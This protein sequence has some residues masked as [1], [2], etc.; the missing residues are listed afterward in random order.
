MS[1]DASQFEPSVTL[2]GTA[3]TDPHTFIAMLANELDASL[4]GIG[5]HYHDPE[6]GVEVIK[7]R[8]GRHQLS[9]RLRH[10]S[11]P[12]GEIRLH[13]R[14]P[15]TGADID[16]IES[17]LARALPALEVVL[18]SLQSS[19]SSDM[20][21]DTALQN[22]AAL[23]RLLARARADDDGPTALLIVKIDEATDPAIKRRVALQLA[24]VLGDPDR[25]YRIGERTF[26]VA[27]YR[28]DHTAAKFLAERIRMMVAAMPVALPS[29]TVTVAL[30]KLSASA[31][32]EA[33]LV[34]A[35]A[36][37]EAHSA[38]HNRVIT[39]SPR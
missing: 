25:A 1:I 37:L 32:S 20:D 16:R 23:V 31:R 30:T 26:A 15:F 29:P 14:A 3:S 6:R 21:P 19:A 27:L 8:G 18:R 9:Y 4:P 10:Q 7:A 35:E 22:R 13:R 38:I 34:D 12:L 17:I 2:P 11:A 24:A 36:R 33:A 39:L 5:V 28:G